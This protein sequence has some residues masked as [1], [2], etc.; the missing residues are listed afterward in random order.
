[1]KL[2]GKT[3]FITGAGSGLGAAIARRFASEGA[4]VCAT[5]IDA[6]AAARIAGECEGGL[7]LRCDVSDSR[8]VAEAFAAFDEKIGALDILVNNAGIIHATGEYMQRVQNQMQAQVMERMSGAPVTTHMDCVDHITD[9]MFD[10]MLKVHLYGTFYC[11][12]EALPRM[13]RRGQGGRIINMASI[14]GTAAGAGAPDYC[15]AKGAILAF[16]RSTA[17]EASS[18]GVLI[19]AIAP[20][21]IDTPLLA[22]FEERQRQFIAMQTPLARLGQA[23]EIAAAALFLAGPDSTFVTGQVLSPNGGIYM[24]Q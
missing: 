4:R 16:T 3:A 23:E 19:N 8:S 6:E 2:S 12:R 9:E 20:G 1:M 11:T 13:R 7:A 14:M 24:S 10:R 21:Y 18:Y 15:A 22:P 5:D 17:H